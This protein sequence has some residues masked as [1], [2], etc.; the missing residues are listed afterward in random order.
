MTTK[1]KQ[2]INKDWDLNPTKRLLNE[3]KRLGISDGQM[4]KILGLHIYFYYLIADEKPDFK[5]YEMSGEVQAALDNAGF[6]LFYVLTGEYRSEN[7][8]RMLEAFDYAIQELPLDEQDDIRVLV[9]PVYE[10]LMKAAS[11]GKEFA[12]H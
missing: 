9:E 5:V 8:E 2:N 1:N 6:D 11:A 4:A 3:K 10:K 7:Y 12:Q